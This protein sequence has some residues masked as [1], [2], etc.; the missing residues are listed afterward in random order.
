[1]ERTT[2]TDVLYSMI[3]LAKYYFMF[4]GSEEYFARGLVQVCN[5]IHLDNL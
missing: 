2:K 1:M 4:F 3:D 5:L